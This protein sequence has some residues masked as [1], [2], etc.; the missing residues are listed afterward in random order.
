[1]SNRLID[2]TLN[3]AGWGD[4]QSLT[5]DVREIKPERDP[6]SL[7]NLLRVKASKPLAD[8]LAWPGRSGC[9]LQCQYAVAL[10]GRDGSRGLMTAEAAKRSGNGETFEI[11]LVKE[12][13]F[14]PRFWGNRSVHEE[15]VEAA[16]N[17]MAPKSALQLLCIPAELGAG[18]TLRARIL[19][20]PDDTAVLFIAHT[21]DEAEILSGV[22]ERLRDTGAVVQRTGEIYPFAGSSMAVTEYERTD[23]PA[24]WVTRWLG[25]PGTR[26][27]QAMELLPGASWPQPERWPGA[28]P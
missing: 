16:I 18:S 3:R 15:E 12:R 7:P 28:S 20:S 21:M 19:K 14:E 8:I 4:G 2:F 13:S 1:M 10:V 11:E 27:Q 9:A 6:G 17:G 26:W 25:G 23:K 5:L 24:P 22:V